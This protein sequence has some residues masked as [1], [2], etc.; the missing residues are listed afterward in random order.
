MLEIRQDV[1]LTEATLEV[2]AVASP[3]YGIQSRPWWTGCASS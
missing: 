1:Y 2:E 3:Q